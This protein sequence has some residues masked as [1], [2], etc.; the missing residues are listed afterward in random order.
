[1]SNPANLPN[2]VAR[3]LNDPHLERFINDFTDSWLD[4]R[5]L[6]FTNPDETLFPEFDRY[7]QHSMLEETRAYFRELIENLSIDHFVKSDFAMLNWRLAQ[8]YG[9][10]GV[11]SRRS[12]ES[13]P[14]PGLPPAAGFFHRPVFS[15]YRP[16]ER[17]PPVLREVDQ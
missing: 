2:E 9:I 15:K 11:T 8:H 6:E 4:L 5:N 17:T 13:I 10:E 1:M 14:A 12:R 3:L 16:T 7:L